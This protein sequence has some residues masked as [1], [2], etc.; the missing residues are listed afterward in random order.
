MV[1]PLASMSCGLVQT[2]DPASSM[3]W[4][5]SKEGGFFGSWYCLMNL[6]LLITGQMG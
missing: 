5:S 4:S 6:V 3:A 1:E 2:R